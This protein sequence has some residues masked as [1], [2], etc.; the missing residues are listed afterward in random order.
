MGPVAALLGLYV[1]LAL[2]GLLGDSATFDETAHLAAGYTYL[3]R[4]DFRL[5]PEHPPLAKM[6]CALPVWLGAGPAPDY[7]APSW[8]QARQWAFGYE[9]LK[10]RPGA[11]RLGRLPMLALG[12]LLGGMVFAWAREL[13]GVREGL[14][15]LALYA[16]SPTMLA[17]GHLVTTDLPAAF[18]FAATLWA[19]WRYTR[20]PSI[21]AAG[22][23]GLAFGTALLMK[24][25]AV[26][27]LGILPWLA[28]IWLLEPGPVPVRKRAG[29]AA[30]G[31]AG[32]GALAAL[33][34]WGAY[35]FTY[36][37]ADGFEL[38]WPGVTLERGIL[39]S[40]LTF[41][42]EYRLLPEGFL[43]GFSYLIRNSARESFLNG[44]LISGG[45]PA[46]MPTAF[47]LKSTPALLA[48]TAAGAFVAWKR[49]AFRAWSVAVPAVL[50]FAAAVAFGMT[51][52]H[53]HLAPMEPLLFVLA[54]S[55]AGGKEIL[56]RQRLLAACLAAMQAISVA[57]SFPRSLSYFNIAAGGSSGGWRHL[58]DSNLDWGQDLGRLADWMRREKVP[59][60]HL[61]YFGT[62]DP[63]AEG[64]RSK[65]IWRFMDLG[66]RKARELPGPGA[67]V[68]ASVT[69]LQGLYVSD[70]EVRA[71]LSSLLKER[72]PAAKAGDSIFIYKL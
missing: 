40:V 39:A 47:L 60:V 20:S 44:A 2:P 32:A 1:L 38:W 62:A 8:T 50:Y 36:P 69:L 56:P 63:E 34:V 22:L 30:A 28:V 21:D 5:N 37:A 52:G 31:L 58:V 4:N 59:E 27:L 24:F 6:L 55:I 18:G 15:A 14:W 33:L 29:L 54:A 71:F 10:A 70:P 43:Y 61:A 45:D 17:H 72:T 68:A 51:L 9:F 41:S 16:M 25:S 42:R 12:V 23:L 48:A 65:T 46:Y 57:V 11:L 19:F 67:W 66:E 26:M 7:K 13:W 3:D 35:G 64:V 49:D 53:R